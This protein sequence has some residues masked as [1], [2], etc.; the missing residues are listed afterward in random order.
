M[1]A[2]SYSRLVVSFISYISE[3]VFE[4]FKKISHVLIVQ[5]LKIL[6]DLMRRKEK[7]NHLVERIFICS[8]FSGDVKANTWDAINYTK[9]AFAQGVSPFCAH[10]LYPRILDE[11]DPEQRALGIYAGI[12]FLEL[13]DEVWVF[14]KDGKISDGMRLEIEVAKGVG[15]RPGK[16]IKVFRV[17]SDLEMCYSTPARARAR[18]LRE[19]KDKKQ[20]SK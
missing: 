11:S 5:P 16:E 12:K 8:P 17:A 6:I 4:F 14:V 9:Y 3:Y 1:G 15:M 18:A 13:C 19:L 20:K 10:L 7:V 2:R